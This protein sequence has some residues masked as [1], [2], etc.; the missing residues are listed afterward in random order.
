VIRAGARLLVTISPAIIFIALLRIWIDSILSWIAQY[1]L[2]YLG[3]TLTIAIV[4]APC[5]IAALALL[6]HGLG[7]AWRLVKR[8][9]PELNGMMAASEEFL[10]YRPTDPYH[11]GRLAA[12]ERQR[13]ERFGVPAP[14]REPNPAIPNR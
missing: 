14:K 6:Y 5:A 8:D 7:V 10:R 1:I 2:P 13:E 9:L 11:S 12:L 4:F 3:E